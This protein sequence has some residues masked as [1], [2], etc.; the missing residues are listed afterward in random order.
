[1][2][3]CCV[4]VS[5]IDSHKGIHES[6]GHAEKTQKH[7]L[8]PMF[9]SRD[10]PPTEGNDCKDTQLKAAGVCKKSGPT[11]PCIGQIRSIESL[12]SCYP[13]GTSDDKVDL[14]GPVVCCTDG[15]TQPAPPA[16]PSGPQP[17]EG[18]NCKDTQLNAAG[19]CKKSGP[20]GP[21]IGQIRS[22]ES[23]RSCYPSGTSDDKVDLNGPV[24]CC[25]DGVT[26]PTPPTAPV[27]PQPTEGNDCKDT[28]LKAA[29]VCKKSGPTGPCIGQ[30]RSIESLRSCYPSGAS[31]D[32]V[33]LNGPVVCCTDGVTQP[34]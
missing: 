18:N 1:M 6:H 25:T 24:V 34:P 2:T 7:Q 30:I 21:C 12:R 23:L 22:I 27:G 17:T 3:F 8:K 19:V 9:R 28:Q 33:D 29:G 16:A 4:L 11:G 32:K 15:V 31:D 14:N 26:Q 5:A 13:S 20:T 10:D